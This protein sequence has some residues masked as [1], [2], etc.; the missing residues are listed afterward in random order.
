[1]AVMLKQN[2]KFFDKSICGGGDEIYSS[3][4]S[5][6]VMQ[7]ILYSEYAFPPCISSIT[8]TRLKGEKG[9]LVYCDVTSRDTRAI[10]NISTSSIE[11]AL[12]V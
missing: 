8:I 7:S 3:A 11:S 4:D 2:G 12:C 1:M 10:S 5:T 9:N 6:Q